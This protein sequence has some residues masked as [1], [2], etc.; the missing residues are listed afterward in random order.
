MRVPKVEIACLKH[1]YS[2]RLK[3]GEVNYTTSLR[4]CYATDGSR[5]EIRFWKMIKTKSVQAS[6]E[7]YY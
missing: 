5:K 2:I 6:N 4:D 3:V 7:R 1:Y